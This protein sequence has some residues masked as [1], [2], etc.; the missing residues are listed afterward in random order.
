MKIQSIKVEN[1]MGISNLSV[2][3]LGQVNQ[4]FGE[5]ASGKTSL[6]SALKFAFEGT[7]KDKDCL[8]RGA[9]EGYVELT[10]KAKDQD[11]YLKREL[12]SGEVMLKINGAWMKD[13]KN[14]ILKNLFGIHS[15][16]PQNIVSPKERAKVFSSLV[17]EEFVMPTEIKKFENAVDYLP[18]DLD[19]KS[20]IECLNRIQ[21]QLD[22]YR[23]I[24]GR[25]KKQAKA[26]YEECEASHKK[27]FTEA[28]ELGTDFEKVRPLNELLAEKA[29]FDQRLQ[30][31]EGIEIE[32]RSKLN[33]V[34]EL[35]AKKKFYEE[36]MSALKV[37]I[38]NA[39]TKIEVFSQQVEELSRKVVSIEKPEELLLEIQIAKRK[40]EIQPLK[41]KA[42]KHKEIYKEKEAEYYNINGF[43]QDEYKKLYGRYIDPLKEKIPSLD[44][45][46]G[47]WLYEG[48][49]I[50]SLSKSETMR[51]ALDIKRSQGLESDIVVMDNAE[52]FDEDI[53]KGLEL[54]QEGTTY[55]LTKV[56]LPFDME[57]TKTPMVKPVPMEENMDDLKI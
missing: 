7:A 48:N 36:Q 16:Q 25:E 54:N 18:Q 50:Q 33:Q 29:K 17:T 46:D 28:M 47:V 34:K 11:F 19:K 14:A 43:L 8:R 20:P 38:S 3:E 2:T 45:K 42:E 4:F 1:F 37:N 9:K 44:Y 24:T 5:N 23:K 13:R 32:I 27:A 31:A 6:S 53:A 55:F 52:L 22:L 51:L 56:G 15:F 57:G 21:T 10:F 30:D 26:V 41:N 49:S 12:P 39:G 35:E 40:E